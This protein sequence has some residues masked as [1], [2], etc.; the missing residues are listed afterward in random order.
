[1]PRINQ[2]AAVRTIEIK[3]A[4]LVAMGIHPKRLKPTMPK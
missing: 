3:W 4:F 1:M 2:D